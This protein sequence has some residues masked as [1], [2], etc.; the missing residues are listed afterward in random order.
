M[1]QWLE[2]LINIVFITEV[3]FAGVFVFWLFLGGVA[4]LLT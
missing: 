4:L 1:P 2:T 3:C